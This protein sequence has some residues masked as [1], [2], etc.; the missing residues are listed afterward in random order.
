MI[1]GKKYVLKYNKKYHR[2]NKRVLFG[3]I[4][5]P[6]IITDSVAGFPNKIRTKLKYNDYIS[7]NGTA[8]VLAYDQWSMNSVFDPYVAA[9][10]HQPLGFD[11]FMAV[12][13]RFE[14]IACKVIVTEINIGAT[15][16]IFGIC[17]GEFGATP[18]ALPNTVT[19]LGY[20]VCRYVYTCG[21][22]NKAKLAQ[23]S[24]WKNIATACGRTAGDDTLQGNSSTSP[25]FSY[26]AN[27]F[28][29]CLDGGDPDAAAF[30]I[31][32]EYDIVF[33]DVKISQAAN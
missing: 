29:G 28:C 25:V 26:V 16:H 18:P 5:I 23:C 13:G 17:V 24:I 14:V 22:Q 8:G 31:Q 19:E 21:T 2:R 20:D 11:N 12:Y 27:V 9:G 15:N 6:R 30:H 32:L 4:G 33:T 7:L 3:N 10:G 1:K